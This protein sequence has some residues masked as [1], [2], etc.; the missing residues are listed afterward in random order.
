M[1]WSPL[2]NRGANEKQTAEKR[3]ESMLWFCMRSLFTQYGW[4]FIRHIALHHP[5][6]T[7]KA[8]CSARR[9]KYGESLLVST[10]DAKDLLQPQ[11]SIVGV[12]FCMKPQTIPCP[13]GNDLHGCKY[14]ESYGRNSEACMPKPCTECYIQKIGLAALRAHAAFYIMT[15]ARDILFDVFKPALENDAFKTGLFMLCRYSFRPFFVG[16]HVSGIE[17]IMFPYASGDCRDYTTWKKADRGEK[18]E[19]T[20]LDPGVKDRIED[21]IG[22]GFCD[23]GSI[24]KF[25]KRNHIFYPV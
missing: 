23:T 9:A 22:K 14:L 4:L 7:V 8:L 12:G 11:G 3:G 21:L 20:E 25:E 13:S 24:V 5:I 10:R 2:K 1:K 6:K 19:T 18:D 17:G 16:M 15:S